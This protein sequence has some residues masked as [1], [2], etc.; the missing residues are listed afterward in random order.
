[1]AKLLDER[2]TDGAAERLDSL[3]VIINVILGKKSRTSVQVSWNYMKSAPIPAASHFKFIAWFPV[4]FHDARLA[5]YRAR[6]T[7]AWPRGNPSGNCHRPPP[8]L[9]EHHLSRK[10]H[11]IG[12]KAFSDFLPRWDL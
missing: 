7:H 4:S 2:F 1:L 6:V 5:V 8:D 10:E 12:S 3:T 9:D 11:Q